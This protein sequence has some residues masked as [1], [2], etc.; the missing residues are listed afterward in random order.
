MKIIKNLIVNIVVSAILLFVFNKFQL[1]IEIK[2]LQAFTGNE[3]IG[4]VGIFL[5]L[6][7]IFRIFNSPIKRILKT[8]SLPIN[9]L[10]L[11]LFSIV[12]NVLVFY[13]FAYFTNNFFDWDVVV[14]LWQIRQTLILSFIMAA[15]T[16]ILKKIL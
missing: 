5:I 15:W 14:R 8:L 12:I 13:L 11:W 7:L 16:Y 9:A 10:T 2:V 4:L 6:W 1:W 3:I